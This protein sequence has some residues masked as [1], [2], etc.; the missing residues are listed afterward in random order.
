MKVVLHNCFRR[1]FE[2]AV[3]R[4]R[5]IRIVAGE[6]YHYKICSRIDRYGACKCAE[7]KAFKAVKHYAVNYAF[8]L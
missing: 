7:L 8:G 4:S 2:C 6:A 5:R 1:Y 3:S